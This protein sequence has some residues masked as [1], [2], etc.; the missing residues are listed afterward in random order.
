M[1]ILRLKPS[2]EPGAVG[3]DGSRAGRGTRTRPSRNWTAERSRWLYRRFLGAGLSTLCGQRPERAELQR[4]HTAGGQS[5]GGCGAACADSASSCRCTN[6][7][8]GELEIVGETATI[9]DS[10]VEELPD[11]VELLVRRWPGI[12]ATR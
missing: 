9:P 3:V 12:G 6:E 1:G 4:H 11:P 7:L 10:L 8:R 5:L 2:L